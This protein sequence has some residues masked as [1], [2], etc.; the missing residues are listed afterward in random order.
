MKRNFLIVLLFTYVDY[1]AL[2]VFFG[3]AIPL[4]LAPQSVFLG[5]T[6][7]NHAF[8]F[9]MILLIL[10]IG[11]F[12]IG[13]IWGQ[14]SDQYGRRKV[15]LIT[16]SLS[17][18]GFILMAK[19]IS[20]R[21]F[22]LFLVGRII[23]SIAAVN[24][25]I[26][27]ASLAD[28]AHGVKRTI[29]FNW[30]FIAISLG[31]I[32]GPYWIDWTTHNVNYSHVYWV[33]AAIY[34]SAF[35]L[36]AIL[37]EETLKKVTRERLKLALNFERIFT[38]F[39]AKKLRRVFALWIVF[40]M[41]W[42]LFFQYSGEF[43]YTSRH[44]SNSDINFLFS[45]VGLGALLTQVLLVYPTAKKIVPTQIIPWAIV[46]I[47]VSLVLSGLLPIGFGFYSALM[48]Y[49]LGVGFFLTNFNAYVSNL[50]PDNEQGRVLA[51]LGAGQ[52][53]TNIVV[54]FIGSFLISYFLPT[55]YIMG[56][57]IILLSLLLWSK[58]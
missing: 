52:A 4:I 21:L 44:L 28:D 10:P 41:G 23:S 9:G 38:M 43:L 56:G 18:L 24:A 20:L 13:P 6:T 12:L 54:T 1:L 45:Y 36:V 25:V 14:L 35:I 11:Q 30:Q 42:S 16:L 7:L 15:L 40:Q 3:I 26:G 22:A 39:K 8:T 34:A 5:A 55:P 29:R 27:Q 49:C 37:F 51:L 57:V 32:T 31:F 53:F 2:S 47:G 58:A 19:A 46:A 48:L 50:V 33:I 17:V